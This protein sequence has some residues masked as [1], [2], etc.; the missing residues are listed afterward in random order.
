M[1]CCLP[2]L[3]LFPFSSLHPSFPYLPPSPPP[4]LVL[5]VYE[6]MMERIQE[7]Q[8]T[9]KGPKKAVAR[10]SMKK[11]LKG[12]RRKEGQTYRERT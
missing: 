11:G 9:L 2:S 1:L 6:K 8:D 10:W 4:F 7:R 12:N 3:L 5:R